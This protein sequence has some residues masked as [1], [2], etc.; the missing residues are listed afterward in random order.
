M[1]ATPEHHPSRRG[2]WLVIAAFAGVVA[3]TTWDA[4]RQLDN[5]ESLRRAAFEGDEKRLREILQR[6]PD[7]VNS[8]ARPANTNTYAHLIKTKLQARLPKKNPAGESFEELEAAGCGALLDAIARTNHAA[9]MLLIEAGANVNATNRF[10][11]APL[12]AAVDTQDLRTAELLLK[13]GAE[14]STLAFKLY[15]PLHRASLFGKTEMIQLLITHGA[16]LRAT[17]GNGGTP[18]HMAALA[19]NLAATEFFLTNGAN[20]NA[21]SVSGFTPLGLARRNNRTNVVMLLESRG[22]KD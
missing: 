1:G 21:R 17:N 7:V 19:G 13:K 10:G 3:F 15:T 20:V 18:L 16:N 12:H 22:A 2:L 6:R 9:A 8:V 4:M 5:G 14:T 11:F